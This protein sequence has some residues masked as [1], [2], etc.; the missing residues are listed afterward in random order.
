MHST[1]AG[2]RASRWLDDRAPTRATTWARSSTSTR[3]TRSWRLSTGDGPTAWRR[4]GAPPSVGLTYD[5]HA[6]GDAPDE[7]APRCCPTIGAWCIRGSGAEWVQDEFRTARN[8]DQ[9]EK[10]E[11]YSL[12]WR[13]RAQ[14]GYAST[15]S[16][17]IATRSCWLGGVSKGAALSERQSLQFDLDAAGRYEDGELHGGKLG[18]GTRY[19]FRQSP[20]RL[21]FLDL[22]ADA[23]PTSMPISR[24]C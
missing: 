12:G 23:G 5:D 2:P 17:R 3:R 6:F 1:R 18:A 13:A 15:P 10:T 8:R 16:A 21:L 4:L 22:S 24:S 14:L 11:D 7:A 20:R 19:Y 9:I